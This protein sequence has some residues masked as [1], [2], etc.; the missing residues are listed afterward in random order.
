MSDYCF[1][2]DEYC[3]FAL[4]IESFLEVLEVVDCLWFWRF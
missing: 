4:P 3:L 1:P 2:D